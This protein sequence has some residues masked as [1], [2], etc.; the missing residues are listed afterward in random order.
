MIAWG[1]D[2][3]KQARRVGEARAVKIERSSVKP[4][5]GAES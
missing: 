1:Q 3:R 5:S 4:R 2:R